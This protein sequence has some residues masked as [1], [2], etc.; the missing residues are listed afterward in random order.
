MAA[1]M[2]KSPPGGLSKSGT[3]LENSGT[4]QHITTI[5]TYTR[6][7]QEVVADFEPDRL[8]A[9]SA[10]RMQLLFKKRAR[11]FTSKQQALVARYQN[12]LA[13]VVRHC[14]LANVT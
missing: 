5:L 12:A 8:T 13:H 9:L 11:R 4:C 1:Q 6:L 14:L 10:S 2:E 3:G 7:L